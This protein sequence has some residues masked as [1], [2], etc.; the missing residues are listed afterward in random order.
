MTATIRSQ[1]TG[2]TDPRRR[3]QAVVRYLDSNQ[4]ARWYDI[5][6]GPTREKAEQAA[7]NEYRNEMET[8][9]AIRASIQERPL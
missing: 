8:L 2:Y 7:I 6:Y 9:R 4:V 5:H 3:W 1:L